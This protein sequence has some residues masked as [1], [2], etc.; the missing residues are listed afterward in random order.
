MVRK[1]CFI[2]PILYE[3]YYITY[4]RWSISKILIQNTNKSKIL[5]QNTNKSFLESIEVIKMPH[6]KIWHHFLDKGLSINAHAVIVFTILS[7][8]LSVMV[9][10]KTSTNAL[11]NLIAVNIIVRTRKAAMSAIVMTISNSLAISNA[12]K[13]SLFKMKISQLFPLRRMVRSRHHL[14]IRAAIIIQFFAMGT[15][16]WFSR[17][18]WYRR[19]SFS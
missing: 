2:W 4:I 18:F 11:P 19:K 15:I 12:K 5:I 13:W 7:I 16:N 10:V 14:W 3:L 6:V 1:Y 8:I 17:I 9:I